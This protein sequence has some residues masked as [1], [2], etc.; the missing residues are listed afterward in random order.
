MKSIFIMSKVNV[1]VA[2]WPTVCL[3]CCIVINTSS[4]RVNR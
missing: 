4:E 3:V 2:Y 1:V